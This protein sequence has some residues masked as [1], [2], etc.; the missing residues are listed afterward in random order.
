[1]R[2]QS[3]DLRFPTLHTCRLQMLLELP[4]HVLLHVLEQSDASSIDALLACCTTLKELI[5]A[6]RDRLPKRVS[7]LMCLVNKEHGLRIYLE[8]DNSRWARVS[9]LALG[10]SAHLKITAR[11]V[12]CNMSEMLDRQR[13]GLDSYPSH[14]QHLLVLSRHELLM[15]ASTRGIF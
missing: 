5:S 15:V 12:Q 7:A 2:D 1:M 3:R 13:T 8:K 14:D 10:T 11:H 4:V 6:Y 9:I